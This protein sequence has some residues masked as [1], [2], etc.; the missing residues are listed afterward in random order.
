MSEMINEQEKKVKKPENPNKKALARRL[1]T[2]IGGSLGIVFLI[3]FAVLFLNQT[4]TVTFSGYGEKY[5]S[6]MYID[7]ETYKVELYKDLKKQYPDKSEEEIEALVNEELTPTRKHFDFGGWYLDEKFN[8]EPINFAKQMFYA[9]KKRFGWFGKEEKLPEATTVYAKWN[10]HKYLI[11]ILDKDTKE[12]IVDEEEN[13]VEFYIYSELIMQKEYDNFISEYLAQ[14][15]TDSSTPEEVDEINKV[16]KILAGFEELEIKYI[17]NI[18][19]LLEVYDVE[20]IDKLLFTTLD[21]DGNYNKIEK[22][23]RSNN[24]ELLSNVYDSAT[25]TY[26]VD[27]NGKEVPIIRIYVEINTEAE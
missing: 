27:E 26:K 13:T 11:E 14:H 21:K 5:A 19:E 23:D 25:K 2:I 16:A 8:G 22:I 10:Q 4:A 15:T 3:S 17:T 6:S 7:K 12:A 1:I 9:N 20:S 18:E 24:S